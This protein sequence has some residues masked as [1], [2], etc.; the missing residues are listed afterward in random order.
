M[1]NL[2]LLG[3]TPSE[4]KVYLTLVD[5]GSSLAGNIAKQTNLTRAAV[6]EALNKLM[7][8]GLVNYMIKE[9]RKY[10]QAVNPKILK[11]LINE[12]KSK[13]TDLENQISSLASIYNKTKEK[14]EINIY[15]SRKGIRTILNDILNYK[16]YVVFGSKGKFMEI[17]KH[18]YILFQKE[19]RRLKIKAKI[20]IN[21]STRNSE[22]IK[23]AYA[24][25]KFI[26]N[27]FTSL[28]TTFIYGDKTA[29]MMWEDVPTAVLI[30]SKKVYESY[31]KYFKALWKIAKP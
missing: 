21:E 5:I 7:N 26:P 6:Y 29:I 19:K 9:N 18:D 24:K 23:I 17:M 10:F 13:F 20:I 12:Q 11:K 2:E 28:T 31:K 8:K 16:E 4:S 15:Q 3:L 25:F 14:Q 27:K 30:K 22:F 1:T